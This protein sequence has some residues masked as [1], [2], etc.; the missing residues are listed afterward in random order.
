MRTA[1]LSAA[2]V[3]AGS[4]MAAECAKGLHI[5]VGRGTFEPTGLGETGALAKNISNV[6][7]DSSIVAVN[8]PATL[9]NPNYDVSEKNGTQ[10]VYDK[11]TKYHQDCPG[12]KMAYLG[13]SQGAQIAVNAFCGGQGGIFGDNAPIPADAVKD[14]ECQLRNPTNRS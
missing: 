2:A 1:T 8:Y 5:I 9:S 3:L 10:D 7:P 4:A 14:G 6:I 12:H 13:W 11:V